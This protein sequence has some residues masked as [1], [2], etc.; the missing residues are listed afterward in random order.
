MNPGGTQETHNKQYMAVKAPSGK[1][2]ACVLTRVGACELSSGP[3]LES[4]AGF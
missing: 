2:Y 4:E 1:G 3:S